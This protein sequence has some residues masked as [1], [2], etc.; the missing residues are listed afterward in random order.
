LAA[1]DGEA[2]PRWD[3][4][5]HID[6]IL[7]NGLER[8]F[9]LCSSEADGQWRIAVL[10]EDA[11]RGGSA[12]LHDQ[13]EMGASLQVRGPRN[14]FPL[15]PAPS[16]LFIAGGIGITPL[17]SM[18]ASAQ[19]AATPWR[20]MYLARSTA[21]MA[22]LNE[23]GSPEE[24]TLVAADR[25][26]RL[27]VD[28]TIAGCPDDTVV[29]CCGPER[30]MSAVLVAAHR[31]GRAEPHVERFAPLPAAP[32]TTP[33]VDFEVE[34]QRSAVCYRIGPADS[35]LGV[36]EANGHDP[37]SS[38]REGTCGTCETG[39]VAGDIDHRDVVLSDEE[40]RVGA[41]MMI[42]VSRCRGGR[43]VLDL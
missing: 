31:L 26:E 41:T 19:R 37:D 36:L 20:L 18:I 6:L 35:I 7:P 9:S 32:V 25:G 30:L 23:I 29:Y 16:Y 14:H 3:P 17:L 28:A 43:L 15:T 1:A 8:Q 42:C 21:H 38:C 13:L 40:R 34:L 10:R 5:A 12:W 24:V 33:N 4:G 11:G 2:L 22:F 39:V 27:D